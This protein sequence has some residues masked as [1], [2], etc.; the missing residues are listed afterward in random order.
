MENQIQKRLGFHE[1]RLGLL[2]TTIVDESN[3][4]G[5]QQKGL[6]FHGKRLGLFITT[7]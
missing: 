3:F 5:L 6:G 1:K 4:L 2:I 7:S